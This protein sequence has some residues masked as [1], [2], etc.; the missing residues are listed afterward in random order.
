MKE[1]ILNRAPEVRFPVFKDLWEN[2]KYG[3]IFS[4]FSTNSLSRDNLNYQSGEVYN[5]HYGD[6][7]KSFKTIFDLSLE[8]VPYI[9]EEVDLSR[10]K[11]ENYCQV[12]DLVIADASED[13][14]DIGK[15][16]EIINLDNQKVIAGLHTFLARPRKDNTIALG[17]SGY[18][19]QTWRIR[20][21]IM[22]IAQGTK[23]LGLSIGRLSKI[24][25][26]IPSLPEQQKIASFLSTV[27]KKIN[28]L[29]SKIE[30]LEQYK[31][32]V[33]QKIF[34]QEI[35]FKDENGNDFPEW[36]KKTL[37]DFLTEHKENSTGKEEVFSVS[38][39]KGLIN[40]IEHL[41]R[42]FAAKNTSN[43]NLVK[44]GDIVYTKSPTGEFPWGIIKQSKL[45][46]NVIVSPL[47]GVFT[48]QTSALGYILD[49][50]F[51]SPINTSNYLHS[52]VQKGAKNTINIT[53]TTFLS[54]KIK[55]PVSEKEQTKIANFLSSLDQKINLHK[56]QLEKMKK[57]KKGLLQKM[58]V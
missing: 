9:N 33:V 45:D 35:R 14:N 40:Q 37:G 50:L 41:G 20:K 2:K 4:F 6:I 56:T 16:I 27:D 12:G 15:T 36:E 7:H 8:A 42:S 46:E 19:L 24:K 3:D 28:L 55:L 18:L 38:V 51:E 43:Y 21:Q 47:Y 23:V 31:K 53:N 32:G 17:F 5:I 57:W 26:T 44:P 48:P 22:T 29:A 25:L 10:I 39:H 49:A 52:I 1:N 34:K 11:K 58:F 13:Y 30:H 54:K